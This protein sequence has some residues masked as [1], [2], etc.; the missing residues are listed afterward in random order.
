MCHSNTIETVLDGTV[1]NCR[2]SLYIRCSQRRLANAHLFHSVISI[3]FILVFC[4]I[5]YAFLSAGFFWFGFVSHNEKNIVHW[6]PQN[7]LIR[8]SCAKCMPTEHM[9]CVPITSTI[10]PFNLH[11]F[12][13]GVINMMCN[14]FRCCLSGFYLLRFSIH[15][16][17]LSCS[18]LSHRNEMQQ[19]R[20]FCFFFGMSWYEMRHL[21]WISV[22]Y[23]TPRA[24]VGVSSPRTYPINA[25]RESLRFF[26]PSIFLDV[27]NVWIAV[28]CITCMPQRIE[29]SVKINNKN[30]QKM[31]KSWKH[32]QRH[33]DIN[34]TSLCVDHWQCRTHHIRR[35]AMFGILTPCC[36]RSLILYCTSSAHHIRFVFVLCACMSV[37]VLHYWKL[38]PIDFEVAW[39]I[40]AHDVDICYVRTTQ[41]SGHAKQH[42]DNDGDAN[43]VIGCAYILRGPCQPPPH[44]NNKQS[45]K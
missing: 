23:Y 31:K 38:F 16:F 24:L 22:G 9:R 39:L 44:N 8:P 21:H 40:S 20:I 29:K 14:F 10:Q 33:M 12:I 1:A 26:L 32:R 13:I 7:W 4:V 42:I 19:H 27:P 45:S 6:I 2:Y 5:L 30:I 35:I 3:F 34:S 28:C 43:A 41:W 37:S 36:R 18:S 25:M 15:L 17:L 11:F